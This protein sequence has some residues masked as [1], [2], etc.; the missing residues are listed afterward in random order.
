MTL[1]N[2]LQIGG[3]CY[4]FLSALLKKHALKLNFFKSTRHL[5]FVYALLPLQ[6]KL[7]RS[8]SIVSDNET[9]LY[10]IKPPA[11]CQV[12]FEINWLFFRF[13]LGFVLIRFRRTFLIFSLSR[14]IVQFLRNC[15]FQCHK[16]CPAHAKTF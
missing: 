12:F 11:R 14:K 3:V 4:P 13:F 9:R 6:V 16:I 2:F 10:Y 8:Q 15:I 5:L 1:K 7:P